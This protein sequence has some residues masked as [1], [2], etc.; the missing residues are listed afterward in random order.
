MKSI[1]LHGITINNVDDWE[2]RGEYLV[3]TLVD[4]EWWYY[5]TYTT[6]ARAIEVSFEAPALQRSVFYWKKDN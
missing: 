2:G 6:M 1:T 5:G 4:G 3:A